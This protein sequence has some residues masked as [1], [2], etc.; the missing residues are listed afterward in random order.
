M[1]PP[2]AEQPYITMPTD[3]ARIAVS[4]AGSERRYQSLGEITVTL[5]KTTI[6]QPDPTEAELAALMRAKAATIGADAIIETRFQRIRE[7]LDGSVL[8]GRGQAIKF[9]D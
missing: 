1:Q 8:E 3:P 7:G 4:E 9:L 2:V 5:H 6:L